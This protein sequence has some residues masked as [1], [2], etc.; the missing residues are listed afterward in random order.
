MVLLCGDG[1][2]W[3]GDWSLCNLS[4]CSKGRKGN[5]RTQVPGHDARE[6]PGKFQPVGFRRDCDCRP[7]AAASA[8]ASISLRRRRDEIFRERIS[9]RAY[10]GPNCTV[11]VAGIP[12][13]AL[14]TANAQVPLAKW[15]PKSD[16]SCCAGRGRDCTCNLRPRDKTQKICVTFSLA[17]RRGLPKHYALNR[18]GL[19]LEGRAPA[20]EFL[21]RQRCPCGAVNRKKVSSRERARMRSMRSHD[22]FYP[23]AGPAS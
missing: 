17:G 12:G 21:T 23:E 6:G 9:F 7:F 4:G 10:P 13:S 14:W 3:F 8:P 5:A 15:T 1:D 20:F 19:T 2:D 16:R 18:V 11:L 22:K